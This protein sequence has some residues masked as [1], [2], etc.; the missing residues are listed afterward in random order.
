M[1]TVV[2]FGVYGDF[3]RFWTSVAWHCVVLAIKT[4]VSHE[5]AMSVPRHY[6]SRETD[7]NTMP[8]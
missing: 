1:I 7:V 5:C 4:R 2:K 8:Y 3:F 6:N